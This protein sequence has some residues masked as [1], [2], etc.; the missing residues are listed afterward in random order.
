MINEDA[1]ID[2]TSAYDWR[3]KTITADADWSHRRPTNG[4]YIA[5]MLLT[6]GDI[7][8][9]GC[10]GFEAM[11]NYNIKC[12]YIC[13]DRRAHCHNN[14]D[15]IGRDFCYRCKLEWLKMPVDY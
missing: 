5:K 1:V 14:Y 2:E 12:P 7:I 4:E 13:G 10:A 3:K 11:V 9:D 15:K 6:D 8:D